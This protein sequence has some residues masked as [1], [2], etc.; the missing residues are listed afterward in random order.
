M[1]QVENIEALLAKHAFFEGM[2]PNGVRFV[3]GC[4]VNRQFMPGEYIFR[5]GADADYFY[6]IRHGVIAVELHVPGR[7]PMIVDTLG[8]GDILGSSWIIPPYRWMFDARV[9]QLARV[10]SLDAACLRDKCNE[11]PALGYDLMKRFAPVLAQRL[12][13][14]RLRLIDMYGEPKT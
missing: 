12:A 11:D 6:L 2:D 10:I 3:A 13:A 1:G 8:K 4:G 9:M 7:E 14:A 5:E